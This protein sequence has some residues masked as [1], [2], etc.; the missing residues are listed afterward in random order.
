MSNPPIA[1]PGGRRADELRP[2]SHHARLHPPRRRLGADR[3]AATRACCAPRA[4]RRACPP[5][6]KGK[7]Q[8]WLTA[9]YGMLPRATN[10]RMRREAA[11]GKQSGRTQEIQRLIGR[12][13][14]RSP[15]S[16]RSASARSGSTATCCRPTAAR[17]ARRSPA[18]AS[19]SPTPS[20]GAGRAAL[21]AGEPLRDLVAAVSVGVVGGVPLLDLDY[22]EDSGCDTDMN[23]V[24]TGARRLRRGAGHRRGRAVHAR[25]AGRAA[26]RSAQRGIARLVR[27]AE[28]RRWRRDRDRVPCVGS[29]SPRTTRASCASSGGCSRRSASTW[30]RRRELGIPEADEPH[31]DLRRE[32]ARQGAARERA[33]AA[34]GARRR[35][36]AL[37]RGARRRAGRA[38]R[39]LRRRAEVRRAQQREAGR[40][41]R[42]R[43]RPARALLLRA[44]AGAPRRRPGADHRRGP[45]ARRRSS[46]RRAAP[47]ASATTRTS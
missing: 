3:R 32:R 5:F 46:T 16:P 37:R 30:S 33:G 10:T 28:A 44:G 43:R 1:R 9:E 6:L 4:S 41:A 2:L 38:E 45:L 47:A 29:S 23:V 12:C 25:R 31:V 42:G 7:G 27:G 11:E 15:T 40:G 8:G 21:V 19:R 20:R 24:M 22:A 26:R 13:C 17:A 39:A 36:R 18:P 35:L 14:A 34:A